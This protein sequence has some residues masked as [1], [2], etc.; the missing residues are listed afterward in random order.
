MYWLFHFQ[1]LL[2]FFYWKTDLNFSKKKLDLVSVVKII[3][4]KK[5][6]TENNNTNKAPL[7]QA[8]IVMYYHKLVNFISQSNV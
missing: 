6:K 2:I 3:L 7:V 1:L 5:N 8:R 4:K